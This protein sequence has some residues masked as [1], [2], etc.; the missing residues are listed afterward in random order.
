MNKDSIFFMYLAWSGRFSFNYLDVDLASLWTSES[1][2]MNY[3][4][5]KLVARLVISFFGRVGVFLF[6][7]NAFLLY[8]RII[9][10]K[11]KIYLIRDTISLTY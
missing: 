8:E 6:K 1:G 11:I 10:K 5:I 7:L 2:Y 3:V 4:T 9:N